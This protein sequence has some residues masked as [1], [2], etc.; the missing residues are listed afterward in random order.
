MSKQSFNVDKSIRLKPIDPSTLSSPRNGEF[1]VDSTDSNI[2]KKYNESTSSWEAATDALESRLIY[3]QV[4]Y[5]DKSNTNTYT[6]NGSISKPFKSLK[7]MYDAITDA[8]ASKK[9]A[10]IIAPGSY[11]EQNTLRLKGYID[12]FSMA[13]DT[14]SVSTSDS[15][16]VKWSN[17]SPGRV[18]MCKMSLSSGIELLNDNPSGTSGCVLDLDNVD[19]SS[20]V[21]NGRGGGID[22]VQLRNDTR[23]GGN[24][25]ISSAATTIFDSTIIGTLTMNDTG[26]LVPDSYG[27][28]ITATLKSN[29]ELNVTIVSSNYD[30]YV[31]AWGNNAIAVLSMTSNSAV[32]STFNSDAL[33]YPLS[34]SLSGS[35]LPSLVKTTVA[36]SIAFT[37]AVSGDWSSVP[38]QVKQAID[39][40]AA[41]KLSLSGGTMTGALAMGTNKITGLGTPTANTDAATKAYVDNSISSIPSVDLT[42][43]LKKDGSVA[44]TGALAMGTNKITGLGT[45]TVNTDAATKAYVDTAVAAGGGGGSSTPVDTAISALDV[46]WSSGDTFYKLISTSSTFT[47]SNTI[48]GK[49]VSVILKNT[50][51][52]SITVTFP[53]G[54]LTT[55]ILNTTIQASK[56]NI[57]TFIKSNDKIYVNV[58]ADLG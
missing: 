23:V 27:S 4:I 44:M 48:N 37:P 56:E 39:T 54:I 33:S 18:F 53:V 2:F 1:I 5:V 55:G 12:L 36:E 24:C 9:Y 30:V 22:Y 26:C 28:A 8:S 49:T 31:D 47:F 15:S 29:Y 11:I 19:V 16:R 46:N 51:S 52:S 38:S 17:N 50:S 35:P 41:S 40:L 14:V 13:N 42:P 57:Y 34:A 3:S 10:V 32:P 25:T 43:Y 58:C 21:V 20:I 45:P 7:A 6:P